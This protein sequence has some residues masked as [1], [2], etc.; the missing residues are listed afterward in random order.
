MGNPHLDIPYTTSEGKGGGTGYHCEHNWEDA[1][2]YKTNCKAAV[3]KIGYP[4]QEDYVDEYEYFKY[5]EYN[6]FWYYRKNLD[7]WWRVLDA[8][9]S[10]A[11]KEPNLQGW[12][13]QKLLDTFGWVDRMAAMIS[14]QNGFYWNRDK[15]GFIK[16]DLNTSY[17][18]WG[19]NEIPFDASR[20]LSPGCWECLAVVMPLNA[21]EKDWNYPYS[22]L[23][24]VQ[25]KYIKDLVDKHYDL[26]FKYG[27]DI[28]ILQQQWFDKDQATGK[29]L[30]TTKLVCQ[31]V[32]PYANLLN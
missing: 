14:L 31:D 28:A 10:A 18:W 30:W 26:Q 25:K 29:T 22:K 16:G 23:T 24:N 27:G 8:W 32:I 17:H 11:I 2:K 7:D 6:K 12:S 1:K 3:S 9:H 4:G 20:A 15:L 5:Y 21:S 19:W 13:K